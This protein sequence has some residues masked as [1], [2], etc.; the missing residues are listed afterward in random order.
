M[1]RERLKL[2]YVISCLMFVTFG[3]AKN[4]M[5]KK[6]SPIIPA[7]P[8]AAVSSNQGAFKVAPVATETPV[9]Q[10][11]AT[12]ENAIHDV[13]E[14]IANASEL[15]ASLEEIYFDFDTATLS[16]KARDIL[17]NTSEIM[18]QDLAINVRV[19]GHCDERGSDEYNLALGERRAKAAMQYLVT[20]GIPE[21]RLSVISFGKEQPAV[22]GHD[23]AS[24]S[25]NRRDEFVI[26]S[27]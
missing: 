17:V 21:K 4:E 12:G 18:K 15:R 6:E 3:C 27:K 22:T 2:F 25:K 10:K 19:E 13:V 16:Q 24:W 9:N 23:E 7:A 5:V 26:T 8:A 20:M 11:T 14:P 1:E